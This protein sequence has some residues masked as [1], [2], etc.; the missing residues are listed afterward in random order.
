MPNAYVSSFTG[1]ELDYAIAKALGNAYRGNNTPGC[2]LV[3]DESQ[4]PVYLDTLTIPGK[5]TMYFYE[6]GPEPLNGVVSPIFVH[7]FWS[8]GNKLFQTIMV[9]ATLYWRDI[10]SGDTLWRMVDMGVEATVITNSLEYRDSGIEEALSQRMGTKLKH[11]IE[12]LKIGNVNLIDFSNGI[13]GYDNNMSSYWSF[14][15]GEVY[16]MP[17]EDALRAYDNFPL[18]DDLDIDDITL[19]RSTADNATFTSYGRDSGIFNP[20]HTANAESYTASVYLVVPKS[21]ASL[22]NDCKAYIKLF[23]GTPQAPNHIATTEIRLNLLGPNKVGVDE[24]YCFNRIDSS[25]GGNVYDDAA[26]NIGYYR[27]SV[28]ISKNDTVSSFGDLRIQFGFTGAGARGVMVLPKVEYGDYAT[29]YNHS[30][31]DLYYFFTNCEQI[32]GLNI[33]AVGPNDFN[34]QD[35]LVFNKASATFKHEAVAVGGGGGF[36]SCGID[37]S[38]AVSNSRKDKILVYERGTGR[39]EDPGYKKKGMFIFTNGDWENTNVPTFTQCN[40]SSFDIHG[41]PFPDIIV[42]SEYGWLDTTK[43]DQYQ[44]ATLR[45]YDTLTGTWRAVGAAL[46]DSAVYYISET[47]DNTKKKLIWIKQSTS[48]PY[49]H[50]GT[51]WVPMLAVW[52]GT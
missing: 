7:V 35:G 50:D 46:A 39:P 42:Q 48:A 5:Y 3:G 47:P 9:G 33:D 28:T 22:G 30:W 11:M 44:P 16:T 2:H 6:Q 38:A 19:F 29:Q 23:D 52:G 14:S 45:Y 15:N 1:D 34:E 32:F 36:L 18:F 17:C 37:D 20:I 27:L 4:F 25:E 24:P 21:F 40:A 12:S 43:R 51:N 41:N 10:N 49:Y 26:T 8:G 13:F 31:G